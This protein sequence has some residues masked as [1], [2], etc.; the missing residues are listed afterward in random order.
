MSATLGW[1]LYGMYSKHLYMKKSYIEFYLRWLS[2]LMYLGMA[3]LAASSPSRSIRN[4]GCCIIIVLS[5]Y[6]CIIIIVPS[7]YHCTILSDYHSSHCF[8]T[9]R[10]DKRTVAEFWPLVS[11][12]WEGLRHWR[13]APQPSSDHK[14]VGLLIQPI[15]ITIRTSS[16][17]CGAGL[18]DK[19]Q[20]WLNKKSLP[21]RLCQ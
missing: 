15:E 13:T 7:Y 3:S 17:S 18:R 16:L 2:M 1:C 21:I 20:D 14:G 8:V 6:S 4:L 9:W 19:C 12:D 11:A 5:I 10:E